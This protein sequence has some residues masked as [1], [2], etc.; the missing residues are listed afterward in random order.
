MFT[1][2]RPRPEYLRLY[3]QIDICLDSYPYGGHT[4]SMD[5]IWMG[6]PVISLVGPLLVGRASITIAKNL[7]LEQLV[8]VHARRLREHSQESC[9]RLK[10]IAR[11]AKRTSCANAVLASDER[12]A[13]CPRLENQPIA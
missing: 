9:N 12:A 7:Q 2:R 8:D 13:V 11:I 10:S 6:I 3:Q 1:Q 5:A 4:T